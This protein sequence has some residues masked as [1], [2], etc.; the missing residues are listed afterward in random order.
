[1]ESS[2]PPAAAKSPFPPAV[3]VKL[4]ADGP[5]AVSDDAESAFRAGRSLAAAS[6]DRSDSLD[7]L[8]R[9]LS[10]R[11][12]RAL[13]RRP[14][15]RLRARGSLARGASR[16]A[17][18]PDL[19][20][21]YRIELP[22]GADAAE[23]AALYRADPHVVWAQIEH[24]MRTDQSDFVANDPFLF[25]SGSWG[26][27]YADLWGLA[28]IRAQE[29]WA[30]TRGEGAV[31]AVVDSGI[32]P[33]HPDIADN[34]WVNPGEDLDGDGRASDADRNGVDDDGNGFVDDLIGYDFLP[35]GDADPFD[36]AG[37][38]THVAGTAVAVGGNGTGILGVAPRAQ[39]MALKGFTADGFGLDSALAQG[40]VYAAENGAD[41]INNSWS[42]GTRCPTN[43]VIDEAVL[44]A[45]ALGTVVV[46]S[47]GNTGDDVLFQSP[48]NRRETI[49]VAAS[50]EDDSLAPFSSRGYLVDVA[51]PGAGRDDHP[52]SDRD[53][54]DPVA[55]LQR[56]GS[57][58]QPGRSRRRHLRAPGRHLDVRAARGRRGRAGA[59]P[60]SG[61]DARGDPR[62]AA[63]HGAR[64]RSARSRPGLWRRHRGRAGR[65]HAQRPAR[66]RSDRGAGRRRDPGSADRHAGAARQR[67]GEDFASYALAYGHGLE[68][69]AFLPIPAA[70][71]GPVSDGLLG[72][73]EVAALA[74][75]PYVLRLQVTSRS[76]E[77]VEEFAPLSIEHNHPTP[78][79]SEGPPAFAADV[80]GRLV[81]FQ[82]ERPTE[83]DGGIDVFAADLRQGRELALT[84]APGTQELPRVSGR[85]V[86]YRDLGSE[87][88]GEIRSCVVDANASRCDDLA[89]AVGPGQRSAPVVSGPRIYWTERDAAGESP[90]LC[91]LSG[92]G[93]SC[94]E[95]VVAVRPHAQIDL[96]V[97][98]TR[99]LWRELDPVFSVWSC[100]L[101]P[102]SGA[103]PAQLVNGD[104]FFQF[105][106]AL[107]GLLFAWEQFDA[108]P[109]FG[110]GNRV[111]LCRLDPVT[112]SCP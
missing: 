95:R 102:K 57:A 33:S 38:G 1:M 29:A 34:L 59:L 43:P 39:L 44:L 13:F 8:A 62:A 109:G 49:A 64:Q 40:I 42:C 78:V 111:D 51:A 83:E 106:P 73:W 63:R 48:K 104:A 45:N 2:A 18:L 81:V 88:G 100:Q 22:A 66:P 19:S 77:R 76:G 35:P 14:D 12:V 21:I 99:L 85:R 9:R 6:A 97:S 41:V 26:Q 24:V 112:G 98:G 3:I 52:D 28:K 101:D 110:F 30:Y 90:R 16:Q 87:P 10:P 36:D 80:S 58:F 7:A 17:P 31:I 91:D 15:G 37:H 23:A 11:S 4:R 25:S 93:P 54:G 56:R 50:R 65:R 108:F 96:E 105:A 75:G 46:T 67:D 71:P 69:V 89:V 94:Q 86:V 5:A 61:C 20:P 68:P 74:D 60:A 32:D 27:P 79:S 103:C 72:H 92:G 53:S 107:S 55:A 84:R 47:A 70:G 82:S